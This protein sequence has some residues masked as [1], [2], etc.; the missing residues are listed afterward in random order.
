MRWK[1]LT[2]GYADRVAEMTAMAPHEILG[3]DPSASLHEIRVAYMRLVKVYHPDK[4]DPFMASYNQEMVK[5]INAAYEKM[6]GRL[7]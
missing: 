7:G 4:S 2:K 3:V 1:D 5:L 6:K